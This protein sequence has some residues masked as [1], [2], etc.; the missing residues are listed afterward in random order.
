MKTGESSF[1][2]LCIYVYYKGREI[3][4]VCLTPPQ[5]HVIPSKPFLIY[6]Q[7]SSLTEI[8]LPPSICKAFLELLTP[9]P[10]RRNNFVNLSA[11]P[12]AVKSCFPRR[13]HSFFPEAPSV[14]LSYICNRFIC[15][16]L[17]FLLIPPLDLLNFVH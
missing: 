2:S 9:T 7:L 12:L 5:Y 3:W 17:H 13:Q 15:Q 4:M 8:R 10:P 1:C 6:L 14:N 16:S 11:L